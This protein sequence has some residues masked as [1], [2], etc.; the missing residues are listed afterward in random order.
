MSYLR[1]LS[2]VFLLFFIS[3]A[4]VLKANEASELQIDPMGDLIGNFDLRWCPDALTGEKIEI[5]KEQSPTDNVKDTPVRL[6][7][8]GFFSSVVYFFTGYRIRYNEPFLIDAVL[9]GEL[10]YVVYLVHQ[11]A[12]VD[13]RD[14][15]KY[16]LNHR[17]R[18]SSR[19][20]PMYDIEE[21][22]RKILRLPSKTPLMYAAEKNDIEMVEFLLESGADVNA[23][24]EAGWTAVMIAISYGWIEIAKLL[25]NSGATLKAKDKGNDRMTVSYDE[26][27]GFLLELGADVNAE[28]EAGWTAVVIAISYGWLEIAELLINSGVSLDGRDRRND[29]TI[30]MIVSSDGDI[31]AVKFLINKFDLDIN[32]RDKN[33]WTAY[34]LARRGYRGD[35]RDVVTF[36]ESLG[37]DKVE[38]TL[39]DERILLSTKKQY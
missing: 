37:E 27:V 22:D 12:R 21:D 2:V 35:H 33:G 6:R 8:G 18:L 10:E 39:E 14:Q 1:H 19:A 36:L 29:R 7:S 25:I 11:G 26:M 4:E 9:A 34:M 31:E 17:E 3:S 16:V 15:R 13:I 5:F 23:E 28:N 20:P 38:F 24:S 32:A 30:L